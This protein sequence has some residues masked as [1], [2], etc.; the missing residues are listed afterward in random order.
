MRISFFGGLSF[1]LCALWHCQADAATSLDY[2]SYE[3][4]L[5]ALIDTVLARTALSFSPAEQSIYNSIDFILLHST[6]IVARGSMRNDKRVVEI[7][8]GFLATIENLVAT[9]LHTEIGLGGECQDQYFS[10]IV[11][12][13]REDFSPVELALRPEELQETQCS[14]SNFSFAKFVASPSGR[15]MMSGSFN[16]SL[17]FIILHEVAHHIFGD[18]RSGIDYSADMEIAA[19][20]WALAAAHRARLNLTIGAPLFAYILFNDERR[21]SNAFPLKRFDNIVS[22][23]AAQTRGGDIFTQEVMNDVADSFEA[24]ARKFREGDFLTEKA[25]TEPCGPRIETDY[26]AAI[27]AWLS[28]KGHPKP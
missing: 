26:E 14:C 3:Q 27:R 25:G 22:T 13:I 9:D 15:Q 2:S 7:S 1:V 20:N 19:D 23:L 28:G 17:A 16:L 4:R 12:S 10:Y 5:H 11:E 24:I 6:Q 21:Y 8:A 18:T